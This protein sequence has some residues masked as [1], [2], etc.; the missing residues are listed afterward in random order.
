MRRRGGN[1]EN[2]A[3]SQAEEM[4][5]RREEECLCSVEAERKLLM[6]KRK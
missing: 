4:K 2:G 1:L 3:T 5:R 6:T